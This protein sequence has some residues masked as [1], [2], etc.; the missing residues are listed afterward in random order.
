MLGAVDLGIVTASWLL[1]YWIRFE[2]KIFPVDKGIPELARYL[3]LL[4]FIWLIWPIVFSHLNLYRGRR[5]VRKRVEAWR[6]IRANI[7]GTLFFLSVVYLFR[8]KSEPVSR[9]VFGYFWLIA[10]VFTLSE[11]FLIRSIFRELRRKGFNLRYLLVIGAGQAASDFIGRVRHHEELGI[12][13][14]GCISRDGN[15]AF[16]PHHVPVLGS[17]DELPSVLK[18][19]VVDQ[20]VVALPL[21]DHLFLPQIMQATRD[22]VCDVKIVPDHYQFISLAGAIEEFEGIPVLNVQAT[23]LSGTGL[24]LKRLFDVTL[25]LVLIIIFSPF[26]LLIAILVKLTSPGGILYWQER[27]SVDGT[28]FMMCK[29]R[30]MRIDAESNGVPGWTKPGD[31]RVTRLGRILRSSSLDELP[32]LW[33]VLLG[34]MS[35]VGPRPERPVF[36]VEFRD[37]I[38]GYML[39]HKVPAGLTGWAQV[40][41][42]RGDTSIDRRI[43]CDLFYIQNWS[44]LFDIKI[45]GLTLLRGWRDSNAC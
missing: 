5:G 7:F 13:L 31:T 26:L 32:Q 11:R 36:I 42:W 3:E 14:V 19:V 30:T 25:A 33:N 12:Q 34:D 17:Y 29:F 39:R 37:R 23:P 41:G 28:T 15:E 10:T 21:A 1:A 20:I 9:L 22:S 4:P 16:G 38:P 35:F 2:L 6:I 27:M 45:I 8:E 40:N 24:L 43:E 18:K 44:L